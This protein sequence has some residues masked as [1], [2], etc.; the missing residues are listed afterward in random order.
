[1]VEYGFIKIFAFREGKKDRN[2]YFIQD[3]AYNSGLMNKFAINYRAFNASCR[4]CGAGM[5]RG[6]YGLGPAGATH[7]GCG[8]SVKIWTKEE[9]F[10]QVSTVS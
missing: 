2:M 7:F 4:R 8:G 1:L 9:K 3:A 6:G 10:Q 5:D